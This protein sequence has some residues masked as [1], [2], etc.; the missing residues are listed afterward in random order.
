VYALRQDISSANEGRRCKKVLLTAV[1][2]QGK[3]QA[4]AVLQ[5][6][7]SILRPLFQNLHCEKYK[8][9]VLQ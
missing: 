8:K 7:F 9:T 5:S 4:R 6:L 3:G 1:R 2:V